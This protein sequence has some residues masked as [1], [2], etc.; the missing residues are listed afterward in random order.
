MAFFDEAIMMAD[1]LQDTDE[2]LKFLQGIKKQ[3]ND[4]IDNIIDELKKQKITEKQ[5]ER[6]LQSGSHTPQEG[7][8]VVGTADPMVNA[9]SGE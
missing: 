4:E 5:F 2:K 3:G 6:M 7:Q 1:Q 8:P 9:F